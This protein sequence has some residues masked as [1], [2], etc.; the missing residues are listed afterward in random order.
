MKTPCNEKQMEFKR[1][2]GRLVLRSASQSSKGGGGFRGRSDR[3]GRGA[4]LQARLDEGKGL[5]SRFAACFKDYR[6][7]EPTP[8]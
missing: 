6:D 2:G 8:P 3:V 5:L 1:L 7:A 4:L